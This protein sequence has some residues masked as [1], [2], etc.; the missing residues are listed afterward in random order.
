MGPQGSRDGDRT[1]HSGHTVCARTLRSDFL[2]ACLELPAVAELLRGGLQPLGILDRSSLRRA[3]VLPAA[4]AGVRIDDAFVEEVLDDTGDGRSLPLLTDAL[5]RLWPVFVK[6]N[7]DAYTTTYR[8]RGRV[9]G[10]LANRADRIYGE[11]GP[12]IQSSLQAVMFS[13]AEMEEDRR[14]RRRRAA[15]KKL[16]PAVYKVLEQFVSAR[17]LVAFEEDGVEYFEVAHEALFTSW[18]LYSR[19]LADAEA[20]LKLSRRLERD[21]REWAKSAESAIYLWTGE[22]LAAAETMLEASGLAADHPAR[23]FLAVSMASDR[24]MRER[25]ANLIA[26][27]I[28]AEHQ[29]LPVA[30]LLAAAAAV[31]RYGPTPQLGAGHTVGSCSKRALLRL[32][33]GKGEGGG[34][35]TSYHLAELDTSPPFNGC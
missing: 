28:E 17:L 10:G 23:R 34:R 3:I 33:S 8:D 5:A 27:R 11:A 7:V 14:I 21:A 12:D 16:P 30:S 32:R 24:R 1:R 18:P 22:R 19:W 15:K 20:H 2:A 13:L 29:R 4:Q 9:A 6:G 35:G 31:D 26:A 25:E